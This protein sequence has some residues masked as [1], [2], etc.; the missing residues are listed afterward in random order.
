MR[1]AYSAG[2]CTV[3]DAAVDRAA[4]GPANF[5]FTASTTR[6]ATVK[7]GVRS[8]RPERAAGDQRRGDLALDDRPLRGCGRWWSCAVDRRAARAVGLEAAD[9]EAA[10]GDGVGLL[11][12]A[13]QDGLDEDA[14]RRATARCRPTRR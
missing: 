9:A 2:S 11:V 5:L 8:S 1:D 7:P 10:L 14:A 6:D 4:R 12:G 3:T 13:L